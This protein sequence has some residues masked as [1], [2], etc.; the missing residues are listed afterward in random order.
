L[1]QQDYLGD[2]R[3]SKQAV[4]KVTFAGLVLGSIIA[5]KPLNLLILGIGILATIIFAVFGI[6]I[7]K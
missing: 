2:I 3:I 1:V 5:G 7:E 6:L 4:F